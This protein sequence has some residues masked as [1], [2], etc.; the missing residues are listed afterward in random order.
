VTPRRVRFTTTLSK[1]KISIVI[2]ARDEEAFIGACLDSIRVAAQNF[3]GEVE[4]IVSLNRC[5][6][7]TE[8]IARSFGAAIVSEDSKNLARIR[9]RGAQSATGDVIATIDAD[10]RM[11]PNMLREIGRK[12]ASG[13]SIGGGVA[14]LPD[15]LSLGILVS[16]MVM[17]PYAVLH[18][19]SAGLFWCLRKDFDAI[20]GF[21]EELISLEDVDFAKRLKAHGKRQGK[22]FNT[23]LRGHIVT[24][25]RKFDRF[26]DWYLLTN[27][28]FVFRLISGKD[29]KAADTYYYDVER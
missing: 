10:S 29:R 2:P 22:R 9:N 17:L 11:S 7:R 21:N 23:I 8:E 18:R 6:D 14:I 13:K 4:V 19:L 25:C 12:L 20:G 27:P 3:G 1:M 16:V 28:R 26:G 24:S 15:R 5:T